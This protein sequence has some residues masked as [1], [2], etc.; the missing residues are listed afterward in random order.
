MTIK[1]HGQGFDFEMR[2]GSNEKLLCYGR[3]LTIIEGIMDEVAYRH[4]G[5]EVTLVKNLD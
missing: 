1:D 3:G 2:N 5:T 4:G